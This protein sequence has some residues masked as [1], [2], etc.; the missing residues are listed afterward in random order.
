MDGDG[1]SAAIGGAFTMAEVIASC[2]AS[3]IGTPRVATHRSKPVEVTAISGSE[4][5]QGKLSDHPAWVSAL[6]NMGKL[7]ITDRRFIHL[8]ET[9]HRDGGALDWLVK[10]PDGRLEILDDT[11]FNVRFSPLEA[12]GPPMEVAP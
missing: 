11:A 12:G 2:A 8:T 3:H 4:L 6:S 9:G 10:W 1:T 5:C 7:V